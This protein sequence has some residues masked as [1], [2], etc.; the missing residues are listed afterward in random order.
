MSPKEKKNRIAS[1]FATAA[2]WLWNNPQ[3]ASLKSKATK[4]KLP[5]TNN[6]LYNQAAKT[7]KMCPCMNSRCVILQHF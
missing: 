6:Q 3:E 4:P 1:L 7:F 5:L 2:H